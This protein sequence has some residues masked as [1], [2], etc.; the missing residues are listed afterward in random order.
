MTGILGTMLDFYFGSRAE[1]DRGGEE[2][3]E[4]I[5]QVRRERDRAVE[6]TNETKLSALVK[7]ALAGVD[8]ARAVSKVL[9][10][11]MAGK[12]DG[13]AKVAEKALAVAGGERAVVR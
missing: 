11:E 10:P 4:E 7:K 2:A 12:L 3:L 13:I 6:R 8:I 9:P 1:A 5:G